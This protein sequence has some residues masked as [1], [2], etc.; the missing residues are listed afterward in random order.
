[1]TSYTIAAITVDFIVIL[2][3]ILRSGKQI[4]RREYSDF[5]L[6]PIVLI[7]V[8]LCYNQSSQNAMAAAGADLMYYTW[9][10]TIG[11][12]LKLFLSYYV[13][14]Y[15]AHLAGLTE[16][17]C[18][19]PIFWILLIPLL[20]ALVL[21]LM[22]PRWKTVFYFD[23]AGQYHAGPFDLFYYII[24]MYYYCFSIYLLIWKRNRIRRPFFNTAVLLLAL[25]AAGM[26]VQNIL[27]IV[28]FDVFIHSICCLIMLY[29]LVDSNEMVEMLKKKNA[30]VNEL[31]KE[32][33]AALTK[34]IEASDQYTEGHS[35]RVADISARLAGCLRMEEAEI[36]KVYYAALIH[37]IGKIGINR[38][39][40][41]KTGKLTA[42]EYREMQRHTVIGASI[43]AEVT[44]MPEMQQAARSH[45]E[46]YDGSGYPDGL[47][48][49][50]IPLYARIIAVA[51]AYD[52]MSTDRVYRKHLSKEE[53]CSELKRN[54]GSQFDP[55]IDDAMLEIVNQN[56]V[57]VFHK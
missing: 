3:L 2:T 15:C 55:E 11:V 45:H 19:K 23:E 54:R 34:S 33:V 41:N 24:A 32:I 16:E 37:D 10:R 39:L 57:P 13:I 46:R 38:E 56:T 52:A 42:A 18:W 25:S 28:N 6:F 1:M 53:I 29:I 27:R 40:L 44:A 4:E 8:A 7:I 9:V 22:T 14:L 20:A 51:D 31:M 26:L 43:A 12:F 5:I 30:E 36:Q 50:E 47:K 21:A 49:K 48:G 17:K 35:Q